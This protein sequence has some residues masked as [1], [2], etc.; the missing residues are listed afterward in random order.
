MEQ[1][2][3][4]IKLSN[5]PVCKKSNFKA[6]LETRDYFFTKEKFELVQCTDCD[7]VFTNPVPAPE[8]LSKY[9]DSPDYLSHTANNKS[10]SAFIYDSL[11]SI[12]LKNKYDLVSSFKNSGKVLDIG[13]GT[14][15]F[16]NY[17]KKKHWEVTG[18]EPNESAR[19]F[20]K[21]HY[22]IDVFA[23]EKIE[24]LPEKSFDLVTLWH[25]LEHVPDL[26]GRM[27]DI[28][29]LIKKDGILIIAV[30]N[31]NAPDFSFYKEKWAALDVPRHLY[32]FTEATM[33]TLLNQFGFEV[34]NTFPLKMDAYYVS[35]LSERY[36]KN[37]IPYLKAALNGYRSNRAARKSNNYS[38]MV[39]VAQQK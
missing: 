11:R 17:L 12:N 19:K 30:P 24:T 39:F 7:F 9:Y 5:C 37:K 1:I 29:R 28:L 2:A 3:K 16:L 13:Q 20:A 35:L 15:E 21:Q 22:K 23:E 34:L 8:Q 14:G 31:L 6:F 4:Q 26:H 32:H 10:L 36:R 25:V 27:N 38:S 18:I 33:Q